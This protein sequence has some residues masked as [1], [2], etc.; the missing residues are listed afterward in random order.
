MLKQIRTPITPGVDSA[1][2]VL[3]VLLMFS[4][5]RPSFTVEEIVKTTRISAPSIYRYISLLKEM[6]LME[7]TEYRTYALTPRVLEL[8]RAAESA[9]ALSRII[10]PALEELSSV[11]GEVAQLHRRMNDYAVCSDMVEVPHKVKLSFTLG[12]ALPLHRGA[13]A[14]VLLA[15]M[16]TKWCES[17][18]SRAEPAMAPQERARVL[19]DLQQI[20]EQG[21]GHSSAEVDEGIWAAAAPI[22]VGGRV[23]AAL[24]V[25]G[26]H[27]RISKEK[28]Q[29][30]HSHVLSAA[31]RLSAEASSA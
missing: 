1:R 25:A 2:R 4:E 11:C 18:L 23:I 10:H 26:P 9:F 12:H 22:T 17:Y 21:W 16:G 7:E 24:T 14:K 6:S 28:A 30:I 29:S 20:R 19:R 27:Y 15:G 13:A 31:F 3:Q 5:E 8:G